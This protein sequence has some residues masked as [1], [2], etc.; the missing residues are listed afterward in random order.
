MKM[1]DF[2]LI[3]IAPPPKY[4]ALFLKVAFIKKKKSFNILFFGPKRAYLQN[5]ELI[6]AKV[7]LFGEA[8]HFLSCL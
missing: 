6:Y 8:K 2:L 1:S 7:S 4:E 3:K 5:F